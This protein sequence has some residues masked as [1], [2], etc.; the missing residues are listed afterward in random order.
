MLG[1]IQVRALATA[2]VAALALSFAS[3]A[4]AAPLRHPPHFTEVDRVS[5]QSRGLDVTD[6]DLVNAWGL[7]LGPNTPLWVVNNGTN[8]ATVYAGGVNGDEVEKVPLTVT[9]PGGAP[10]GAAFNDTDD[11][12]INVNGASAPARFLFVSEG[13]DVTA[14]SPISGTTASL[15]AHVDGAVYKGL[16][17]LHTKFGPFLLA[18]DFAG[19]HIDVFDTNFHRVNVGRSFRDPNLP[20]GYSPFNVVAVR[21]HVFVAYAFHEDSED[22]ETQGPGL[23]IVDD[24]SKLGL[25]VERVAS[26]GTLNAP[27]GMAI[28]PRG[29]GKFSGALLVGNFGDGRINVYRHGRFL[30]QLNDAAGRPITIDGLW[31]LLPGT[32]TTGGTRT[33]WFSA[34]PKEESDGLVGQLVRTR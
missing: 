5:N 13:G 19:G 9:I 16:A 22:E 11:F 14:W 20:E 28:A 4:S 1:K 30:G 25:K 17:L 31:A 8:T 7:A 26:H 32:A 21:D 24:Y 23:G 34:G 2:G 29:F 3:P 33:V 10:T 12:V 18:T 15:V 6:P 27:W